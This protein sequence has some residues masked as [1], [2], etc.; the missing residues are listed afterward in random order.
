MLH[1]LRDAEG[2]LLSLH[3]EPVPGG[4][5]LPPDHPEVVAFLGQDRDQ[6]RFAAL[7]A[8]LV[9]VLE[10]LIDALIRLNLINITDLPPVALATLF[11]RKHFGEGMQA[12]ALSLFGAPAHQ[13]GDAGSS[14]GAPAGSTWGDGILPPDLPR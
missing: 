2:R 5:A 9:R 4:E 11:Y 1:V 12:H 8:D 3:R 6:Q 10:D 7:D 14:Q 13:P